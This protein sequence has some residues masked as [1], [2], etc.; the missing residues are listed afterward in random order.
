MYVCMYTCMYIF[1]CVC[2]HIYIYIYIYILHIHSDN[3][4][5]ARRTK[6]LFEAANALGMDAIIEV[7]AHMCPEHTRTDAIV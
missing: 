4:N 1:L 3:L 2:M 5:G 7:H 6:E